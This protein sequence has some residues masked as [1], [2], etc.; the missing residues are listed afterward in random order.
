MRISF[1]T[2]H[3]NIAGGVKN[4]LTFANLL[5][6]RGHDINV[7]TPPP[8]SINLRTIKKIQLGYLLQSRKLIWSKI[9]SNLRRII[10]PPQDHQW[11]SSK[12][13][14]H[15]VPDF[16][17]REMP[18]ADVIVCSGGSDGPLIKNY[19]PNKG[20]KFVFF[21]HFGAHGLTSEEAAVAQ[22]PF[23]KLVL[24]SWIGELLKKRFN[25]DSTLVRCPVN[26]N[27]FYP[28]GRKESENMTVGMLHHTTAWKGTSDGIKAFQKVRR[29]HPE[30]KLLMF[31]CNGKPWLR[32]APYCTFHYDPP[33]IALREIYSSC[34]IWVCPSWT[35]G[36]GMTSAEA[37]ACKC[38]LITTDNGGSQDFARPNETA[39]VSPPRDID[40]LA[41][42][43]TKVVVDNQLRKT[44][45][46]NG[47]NLIQTFTWK[48][49]TDIMEKTFLNAL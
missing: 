7:V 11:L 16:I 13:N 15:F 17:E 28:A 45:A 43:I 49:A 9:T 21:Q 23:K 26:T 31:G 44:L 25:Q 41:E 4:I 24:A 14:I 1:L 18:D 47:Y 27:F 35:E 36:F 12:V 19:R 30:L 46:N 42:N 39:L 2:P 48:S 22:M 34:D 10:S 6:E 40:R 8:H 33:Q 20:I 32:F 29:H 5:A 38:C 37:M 3:L